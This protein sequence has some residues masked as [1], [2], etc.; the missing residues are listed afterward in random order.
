MPGTVDNPVILDPFRTI[1]EVGWPSEKYIAVWLSLVINSPDITW[2]PGPGIP[3][4]MPFLS[5][6]EWLNT[7]HDFSGSDQPSA[8]THAYEWSAINPINDPSVSRTGASSDWNAIE[9]SELSDIAYPPLSGLSWARANQ[10]AAGGRFSDGLGQIGVPPAN[11]PQ[12]LNGVSGGSYGDVMLPLPVHPVLGELSF[13]QS[14]APSVV[15]SDNCVAVEDP[16]W[17]LVDEGPLPSIE[18]GA[19]AAGDLHYY[20]NTTLSV[21]SMTLTYKT[22]TYKAVATKIIPDELSSS[23]FPSFWVL[24]E[25]QEEDT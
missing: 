14:A 16:Q 4:E 6:E 18:Y 24:L 8:E 21:S 12:G 25:R 11:P 3:E 13:D 10:K 19:N 5:E 1:I 15:H 2:T 9:L 7:W 22:R 17:K 23:T 20:L